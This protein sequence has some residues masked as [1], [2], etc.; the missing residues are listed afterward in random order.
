[1]NHLKSVLSIL[2]FIL[3]LGF[4]QA[5]DAGT[6]ASSA[7][8]QG[9][10]ADAAQLY[11]TAASLESDKVK[12]EGYYA[13]AKKSRTCISLLAQVKSL[14]DDAQKVGT[15]EAYEAAKKKC[16]ALL[17]Y[18]K[19][20]TTAKRILLDCET[21]IAQLA[22]VRLDEE[23]WAR[24][25]EGGSRQLLE[26]YIADF[27]SGS[28]VKEAK[29]KIIELD[30][31][32]LWL[33]AENTGTVEAYQRYLDETETGTY[34]SQAEAAIGTIIDNEI[35]STTLLADNE[36]AYRSYIEDTENKY[37]FHLQEAQAHLAVKIAVRY[38]SMPDAE[39]QKVVRELEKAKD[40]IP[41]D[42]Q[43]AALY[44]ASKEEVDYQTFMASPT[45]NGGKQFLVAYPDGG[46]VDD[47][48]NVIASLYLDSFSIYTT[49]YEFEIARSYAKDNSLKRAITQ[50]E[51]EFKKQKSAA[52][53][54]ASTA[55]PSSSS[56]TTSV[57]SASYGTATAG[58]VGTGKNRVWLEVGF[59][60]EW[61][62]DASIVMPK[63]G[64]RFGAPSDFFNFY[65]GAK[66]T[67]RKKDV[68]YPSL[69]QR[70]V[71]VYAGMKFGIIKLGTSG[72]LYIAGEASYSFALNTYID[73]TGDPSDIEYINDYVNENI[74]DLSGKI[75]IAS[76]WFDCGFFYKHL[77]TPLFT[78]A[79]VAHAS[80]DALA[81]QG[82]LGDFSSKY[83][84]GVYM[85]IDIRLGKK[86]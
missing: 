23:T 34:K 66:F 55:K 59:D 52:S 32:D 44:Q 83:R 29:A 82:I 27:P 6:M 58:K 48:S 4:A 75:G 11:D 20:D 68:I 80:Y 3:C 18:N 24:V 17:Q 26:T 45:I 69:N 12:K 64:F 65:L 63:L 54:T 53:G 2:S 47:V 41:F 74:W 25:L 13:D 85:N 19:Y 79:I 39:P 73:H 46:H 57:P 35:W 40:I 16:K 33:N 10:Y 38:A 62:Q 60:Y 78:D 61:L 81:S 56:Y 1:M 72:R 14:Y 76:G 22:Q 31:Y 8:R 37:K 30:D 86:K 15:E 50:K 77:M 67:T 51:N 9:Q 28:H 36:A 70:A 5:Q 7:F 21:Q 71:P 84:L 42:A 43:T 49:A